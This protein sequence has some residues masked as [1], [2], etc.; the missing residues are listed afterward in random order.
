MCRYETRKSIFSSQ[1]MAFI[2][3]FSWALECRE[4][5]VSLAFPAGARAGARASLWSPTMSCCCVSPQRWG[6]HHLQEPLAAGWVCCSYSVGLGLQ[7]CAPAELCVLSSPARLWPELEHA[8]RRRAVGSLG[9][10]LALKVHCLIIQS[11]LSSGTA[12]TER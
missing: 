9:C 7:S 3:A 8:V 11:S 2:L 10:L 1:T 5:M 6:G 4:E 12:G